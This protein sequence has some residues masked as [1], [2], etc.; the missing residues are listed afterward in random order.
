MGEEEC[1]W[2]ERWNRQRREGNI[3]WQ[4]KEWTLLRVLG[5]LQ[6]GPD[7]HRSLQLGAGTS[8]GIYKGQLVLQS[9]DFPLWSGSQL[10]AGSPGEDIESCCPSGCGK[11]GWQTPQIPKISPLSL[12]CWLGLPH[13]FPSF[14]LS[15]RDASLSVLSGRLPLCFWE[16]LAIEKHLQASGPPLVQP[17]Y[18]KAVCSLFAP[19]Q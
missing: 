10:H 1:V 17:S 14:W 5:P 9:R 15:E 12:V 19:W 4:T 3:G 7:L 11:H 16:M 2:Q 18:R 6:R 13:S 8:K